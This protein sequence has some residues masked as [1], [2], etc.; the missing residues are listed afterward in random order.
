MRSYRPEELFD[1]TGRLI[2]ELQA[3][4]P[5][6]RPA[7]EREPARQ[8]R[9]AAA[10]PGRCPTSATTPCRSSSPAAESSAATGVLGAFLRDIIAAQPGPA[11]G[12][13][14]RTR[15]RPTGSRPVFEATDR[16][17]DARALPGD[18]HLAAGRPG[19]GGALRAPVPGLAGGLPAHRPA[20]AVQLLRGVHP[21]RRLD[22][23]PARQVAQDHPAHP[24]AGADRVAELPA[25]L[26]TSG[27]RTT[28]GCP[29]RTRASSTTW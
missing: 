18:D 22:V 9:P 19:D 15:P 24:V 10:R 6:G 23:Q 20:R 16:A 25:V 1:A 12:S 11:S 29:T 27:A 21:H 2:P 17:W 14:A 3:L 7:D 4:A 13:W 28:T 8:R 26:A 5:R